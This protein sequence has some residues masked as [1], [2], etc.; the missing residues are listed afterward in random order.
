MV[1][2]KVPNNAAHIKRNSI[3]SEDKKLILFLT[4]DHL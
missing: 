4:T 2:N 1:S 3:Y